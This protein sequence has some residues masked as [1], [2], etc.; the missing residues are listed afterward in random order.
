[1]NDTYADK[2]GTQIRL[3]AMTPKQVQEIVRTEL[4]SQ[5]AEIRARWKAIE[6][7]IKRCKYRNRPIMD[8]L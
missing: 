6:K 3:G 7:I 8:Q 1:M 2:D 4:L 5:I